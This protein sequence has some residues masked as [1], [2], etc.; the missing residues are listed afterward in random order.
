M[1]QPLLA[2]APHLFTTRE[3]LLGTNATSDHRASWADVAVALRVDAE[4][5]VRVHQVHGA[6]ALIAHG[7]TAAQP[8]ADIIVTIDPELALAVG[9][10]DCVPLLVVDR[11]TGAVAAAHAG[12]R[13]LA[14]R[15]PA[16]TVAALG[17][18]FG[19]RG[20]DLLA[21]IG[22][23]IGA[24]CYEVGTD[25]KDRFTEADFT[26]EELARWF[27]RGP[28]ESPG[29]PSMSGVAPKGRH[30]PLVF[31]CMGSR[32]RAAC[33]GGPRWRSNFHRRALHGEPRRDLLFVPARRWAHR[34]DRWCD[35]AP[36]ASSIAAF[37][38]RSAWVFDSRS[39]C[40]KV[41][42]PISC[43]SRRAFACSGCRPA[44][45]TL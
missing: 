39:T 26:A 3:W 40:S 5:L 19:A 22:P 35:Q 44:C 17:R 36:A 27:L 31:R 16:A 20:S 41:T 24:C 8:D 30:D 12:W 28:V 6:S 9:A 10:A 34:P 1:C 4:Q 7:R 11:R 2:V 23:S 15:V 42:F 18:A 32:A 38:R 21:A 37:A 43:A 25:V 13:G 14:A 45:L 29:N 33:S